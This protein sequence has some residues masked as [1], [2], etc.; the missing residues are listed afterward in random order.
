MKKPWQISDDEKWQALVSCNKS[1]DGLFLYGVKTTK[2]FCRPSC[3]AKTPA[4][5]N[6][7]YFEYAVKAMEAGF[8]PCKKCCPD[9]MVFQ[10]D[11]DLVQKAKELFDANYNKEIDLKYISKQLGVS[12]NH[13]TRLFK[14]HTN[15]TIKQYLL[16]LKVDNIVELLGKADTKIIDIAYVTGFKSLSNF[17]RCFKEQTGYT[18]KQYRKSRGD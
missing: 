1:Y 15:L 8:R 13:L 10:P 14:R 4:R 16:K 3:R 18:P 9:Q 2:I 6:A 17:Y 12:P 5:E 7:V 11:L